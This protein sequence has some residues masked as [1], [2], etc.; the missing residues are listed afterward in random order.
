MRHITINL[1][2]SKTTNDSTFYWQNTR[3]ESSIV[4]KQLKVYTFDYSYKD[5]FE[6]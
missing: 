6:R 2:D 5:L 4:P 3:K 1:Y